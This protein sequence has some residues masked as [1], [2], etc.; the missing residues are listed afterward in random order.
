[1]ASESTCGRKEKEA[2]E[3][4]PALKKRV[5]IEVLPWTNGNVSVER[6]NQEPSLTLEELRESKFYFGGGRS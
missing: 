2:R 4:Y 5:N 1:M 6:I 3:S